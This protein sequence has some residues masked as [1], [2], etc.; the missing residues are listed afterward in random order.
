MRTSKS[1][2]KHVAKISC[3]KVYLGMFFPVRFTVHRKFGDLEIF[4]SVLNLKIISSQPQTQRCYRPPTADPSPKPRLTFV[5]REE[6]W[7]E[8]TFAKTSGTI[9]RDR[10]K[11]L[12]NS[13]HPSQFLTNLIGKIGCS[14]SK[15][16][17]IQEFSAKM[18]ALHRKKI[19]NNI[20]SDKEL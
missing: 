11:I 20:F 19:K 1:Q 7:A 18:Q 17:K 8:L 3:N 10:E 2:N 4:L 9:S 6:N 13:G 12:A 14:S 16:R 5:K 15:Y